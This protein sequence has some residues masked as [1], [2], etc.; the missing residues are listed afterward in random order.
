MAADRCMGVCTVYVC[1]EFLFL[2]NFSYL[3]TRIHPMLLCVTSV[4]CE[5]YFLNWFWF[6]VCVCLWLVLH[7]NLRFLRHFPFSQK[8]NFSIVREEKIGCRRHRRRC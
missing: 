1:A 6:I 4:S 3:S 8:K 5:N 2:L 7:V